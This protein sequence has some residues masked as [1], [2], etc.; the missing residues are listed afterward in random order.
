[1]QQWRVD[2]R[3][4]GF[5]WRRNGKLVTFRNAETFEHARGKVTDILQQQVLSLD[6]A[7]WNR[8]WHRRRKALSAVS[9]RPMKKSP[10]VMPSANA[11]RPG[12]KRRGAVPFAG[13]QS[14]RAA[15]PTARCRPSKW[16]PM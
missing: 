9:T 2:D 4:D 6:C 3:L 7:R 15:T 12:L 5:D 16:A 11:W 1:L 10:I 13:A 14:Y 8:L